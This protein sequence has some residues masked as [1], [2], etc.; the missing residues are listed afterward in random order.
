MMILQRL[1]RPCALIAV[2]AATSA[3]IAQQTQAPAADGATHA[4]PTPDRTQTAYHWQQGAWFAYPLGYRN[5]FQADSV[6]GVLT[7]QDQLAEL[8]RGQPERTGF[9]GKGDYN[10]D[11]VTETEA[12]ASFAFV[13]G[14]LAPVPWDLRYDPTIAADPSGPPGDPARG[15]VVRMLLDW[16]GPEA[17]ILDVIRRFPRYEESVGPP[18]PVGEGHYTFSGSTRLDASATGVN[19]SI[20]ERAGSIT[21]GLRC[22]VVHEPGKP[23]PQPL[24]DGQVWD[25]TTNTVLYL[26]FP[27]AVMRAPGGWPQ[28]ARSAFDLIESWRTED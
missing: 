19:Y 14:D 1:R 11:L 25:T 4:A 10:P 20:Y 22:N 9:V 24:C 2:L 5:P 15:D 23:V 6:L 7:S 28:A 21:A 18:P 17:P 3:A 12:I 27:E 13:L 8:L 16:A 26:F